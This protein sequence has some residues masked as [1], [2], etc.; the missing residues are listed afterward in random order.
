MV[1]VE[2]C[3]LTIRVKGTIA[4][5]DERRKVI[6]GG[7]RRDKKTMTKYRHP[8]LKSWSLAFNP[9]CFIW[10]SRRGRIA[11]QVNLWEN[12]FY[13]KIFVRPLQSRLHGDTRLRL[14]L[15]EGFGSDLLGLVLRR[16]SEPSG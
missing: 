9:D 11:V 10:G 1:P 7:G 5:K 6:E 2:F 15:L 16:F 8:K 14:W 13:M 12:I 4:M 3:T